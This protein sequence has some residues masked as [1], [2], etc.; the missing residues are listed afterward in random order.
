MKPSRAAQGGDVG[1][2]PRDLAVTPLV[3]LQG[4][5]KSF[6]GVRVLKDVDFDVRPGEVHAL[7]GE[8]GAGKS[9]LIKIMAGVHA[10]DAGEIL[11]GDEELKAR[12]AARGGQGAAS[13]RSTRSCCSFPS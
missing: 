9:T 5:S 11:V 7:L 6:A 3:Q 12:H 2:V 8:N 1:R 10:P 4:M 13:R